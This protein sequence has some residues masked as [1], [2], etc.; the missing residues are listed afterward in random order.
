MG[1]LDDI[2]RF[3]RPAVFLADN[4]K[5]N[6]DRACEVGKAFLWRKAREFVKTT[7][8]PVMYYMQLDCTPTSARFQCSAETACGRVVRNGEQ[9][10]ELMLQRAWVY[11]TTSFHRPIECRVMF[12]EPRITESTSSW[13]YAMAAT[14]YC[15]PLREM[16]KKGIVMNVECLDE[17]GFLAAT[18]IFLAVSR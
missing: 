8:G 17:A 11:G 7:V 13:H 3:A 10:V 6:V 18:R 1:F 5:P 9:T 12:R 16:L 2:K 15:T 4:E 14:E